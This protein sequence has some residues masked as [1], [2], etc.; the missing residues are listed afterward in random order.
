MSFLR[1]I[2]NQSNTYK[3]AQIQFGKIYEDEIFIEFKVIKNLNTN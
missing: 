3:S 1:D 2:I